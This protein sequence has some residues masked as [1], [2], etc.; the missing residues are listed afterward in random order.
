[1]M[2]SDDKTSVSAQPEGQA[3]RQP[4]HRSSIQ[5][6][7]NPNTVRY[8]GCS[9]ACASAAHTTLR[10]GTPQERPDCLG[11]RRQTMD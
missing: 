2:A 8:R 7:P 1:M 9:T 6:S 3:P 10:L 5:K 11:L 4:Q